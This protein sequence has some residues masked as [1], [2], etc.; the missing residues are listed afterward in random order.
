MSDEECLKPVLRVTT[1][2]D[3]TYEFS[4]GQEWVRRFNKYGYPLRRD[5]KWVKCVNVYLAMGQGMCLHLT[6]LAPGAQTLRLTTPVKSI[7]GVRRDKKCRRCDNR[8][9]CSLVLAGCGGPHP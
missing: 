3:S 1:E 5:E 9:D 2:S 8:T 7:E 4:E 6:G